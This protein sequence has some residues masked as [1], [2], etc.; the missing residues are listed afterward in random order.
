MHARIKIGY[1]SWGHND[2]D[3]DSGGSKEK[4][5]EEGPLAFAD[6]LKLLELD[7]KN[8]SKGNHHATTSISFTTIFPDKEETTTNVNEL[9]NKTKEVLSYFN[10]W[11]IFL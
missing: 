2:E 4:H 3:G 9:G 1:K 10:Q 11:N 5:L 7:G 8:K 6:H